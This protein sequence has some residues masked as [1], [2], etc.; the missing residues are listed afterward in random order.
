MGSQ[1]FVEA[2]ERLVV[3]QAASRRRAPAALPEV[4]TGAGFSTRLDWAPL[5]GATSAELSTATATIVPVLATATQ[6]LNV[7]AVGNARQVSVPSGKR[8]VALNLAGFKWLRG[9]GDEVSIFGE[10]GDVRLVVS[11]PDARGEM[12]PVIAVPEVGR[13]RLMPSSFTGASF[14]GG[15]LAFN[16]PLDARQVRLSL[17]EGINDP[18]DWSAE[19]IDLAPAI[20]ASLGTPSTGL[21]L[22]GPDEAAYWAFPGALPAEAVVDL[23]APLA[24]ALNTQL[25][26][27]AAPSIALSL[28]GAAGSKA[29][30]RLVVQ[31]ALVRSLPGVWA[32]TLAGDPEQLGLGEGV[33]HVRLAA[34]QPTSVV[35]DLTVHY[36]GLRLLETVSD[37][38]PAGQGGVA[39][40]IV[41][42]QPALRGFPPAALAGK[43]VARVGIIGRAPVECE[44][45]IQTIDATTGP[46]GP[47]LG[48]PG[49][50]KLSPANTIR[51]AWV[52]FPQEVEAGGPLL[53]SVRA[54][55]GRF[56]WA[57]GPNGPLVKVAIRDPEPAGR[58]LRLNGQTLLAIT[59][60][61]LHLPAQALS[62]AA[63]CSS[64]PRLESDLF[65]KVD[66]SDVVLRYRR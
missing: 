54:T 49:V 20:T 26:S 42:D 48:P 64:P 14:R 3:D 18:D 60:T 40:V 19:P 7:R 16:P 15:V 10:R 35:A 24:A 6:T 46:N 11:I 27:G 50:V 17:T 52:E 33:Q 29:G 43:P 63:F 36:S 21:G 12:M 31:G 9:P 2:G 39:G 47:P 58:P 53:L 38:S 30:F 1:W 34:E 65:L 55:R 5:P 45:S 59:Q 41:T 32:T 25:K 61:D 13:R 23:A 57:T 4:D 51:T 56:L 62:P 22:T 66:L 28:R 8:L 37:A 44:L